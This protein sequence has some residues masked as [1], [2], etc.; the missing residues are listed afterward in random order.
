LQPALENCTEDLCFKLQQT[1][2]TENSH[3]IARDNLQK[4]IKK[5]QLLAGFLRVNSTATAV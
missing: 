5:P 1:A 4:A 2:Y 3:P